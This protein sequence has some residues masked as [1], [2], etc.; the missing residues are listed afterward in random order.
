LDT[1][2]PEDMS[3]VRHDAKE[4]H[5][6]GSFWPQYCSEGDDKGNNRN[7]PDSFPFSKLWIIMDK[8][9]ELETNLLGEDRDKEEEE[10]YSIT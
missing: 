5:Q 7:K 9:K 10:K 2:T 1:P 6:Y 4:T 8:I 3:Q